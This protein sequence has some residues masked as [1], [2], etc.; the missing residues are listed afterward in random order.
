MK[1]KL[2]F[3]ALVAAL[4]SASSVQAAPVQLQNGPVYFQFNNL[5]QLDA[6]LGNGIAVPGG[7][8]DVNG[9]GSIDTPNS[10]GN[11]GVFNLSSLQAG[12]I[13]TPNQDINGGTTYWA[14]GISGGQISGVF[15]GITTTSPTTATGGWMDVIWDE[16]PDV[17]AADLNGA[18]A[19]TNRTA[20]NQVGKFTDGTLLARLE[21]A[22]GIKTDGSN[23]TLASTIDVSNI[24]GSG[25]ADAFANVIDINNDGVIDSLDGAWAAQLNQDWFQVYPDGVTM[26]TR[27]VRFSTFFNLLSA[28]DGTGAITG[29]RSNDPG[30]AF[31]VV[32]EPGTLALFGLGLFGL[33]AAARKRKDMA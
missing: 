4:G 9:D 26:E 23:T 29:L 20:A 33:G 3:S 16:T 14:D 15:Y 7:G 24:T 27:D 2:L 1:K 28:W 22:T 10:E 25:Q 13:A 32:P 31:V 12:G 17:T 8:I 19:P 11:W 30:R 21:F 5:E 6:S 18:Y